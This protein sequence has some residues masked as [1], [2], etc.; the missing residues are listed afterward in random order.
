[1][2]RKSKYLHV[3][4]AWLTLFGHLLGVIGRSCLSITL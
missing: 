2:F 1:M 4:I 3:E